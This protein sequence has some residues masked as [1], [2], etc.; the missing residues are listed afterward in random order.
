MT[1]GPFG[2]G[3]ATGFPDHST[4]GTGGCGGYNI[5]SDLEQKTRAIMRMMGGPQPSDDQWDIFFMRCGGGMPSDLVKLMEMAHNVAKA[6][7]AGQ[8]EQR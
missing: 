7:A 4:G 1:K 3:G 2:G 8:P 5:D 6:Q